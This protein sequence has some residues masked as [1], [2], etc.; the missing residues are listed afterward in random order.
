M[1]E[2]TTGSRLRRARSL[3]GETL[4]R[5]PLIGT[6][7]LL[8]VMVVFFAFTSPHNRAG[9]NVFLTWRNL[10]TIL[11]LSAAYSIGAFAMTV[12][13]LSG[14]IDL[15]CGAVVALA[16]VVNG[17]FLTNLG[18]PFV[19]SAPIALAAGVLVGLANA[20]LIV[21]FDLPPFLAT[22]G[23]AGVIE[24]AA[25]MVSDGKQIYIRDAGF[26]NTFGFGEFLGLP[27]LVWW[28]AFFLILT[29]L[30]I[31]RM[32]FGR[33]LQAIGGNVVAAANSGVNVRR[34]KY[35]AYGFMGLVAAFVALTAGARV[36]TASAYNS[37]DYSLTFIVVAILGG[38]DFFGGGGNVFGVLIGSI[39]IAVFS[40]G[41]NLLG[42][43]TYLSMVLK[44]SIIILAIIASVAL[45]KKRNR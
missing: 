42:T 4:R 10:S 25:Y 45:T 14:G 43:D 6:A 7:T 39:V 44:G 31:S 27:T 24:G 21:E 26:I 23:I 40:N 41:L 30:M 11:E 8:L 33:R 19:I 32:K 5:Y 20:F 18:L 17:Q 2:F 38:T 34:I 15:S 37:A 28:T 13:L 36:Q 29:Y 9:V 12:V 1:T 16:S 22:L 35:I 3:A